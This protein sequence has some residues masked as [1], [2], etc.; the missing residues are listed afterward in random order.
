MQSNGIL[1]PS[2]GL[3]DDFF[4]LLGLPFKVNAPLRFGCMSALFRR[5]LLK[6]SL[7]T[8]RG[9]QQINTGSTASQLEKFLGGITL[10][11]D[12]TVIFLV[13]VVIVHL[14]ASC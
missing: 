9:L 13:C 1:T 3:V 6:L 11:A 5:H 12:G 10:A 8:R 2:S 7:T 4:T 14:L